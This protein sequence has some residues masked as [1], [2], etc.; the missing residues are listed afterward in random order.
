MSSLYLTYLGHSIEV[1]EG[2]SI[3][4]RALS[5]IL[6]FNEPSVSRQHCRLRVHGG[7]VTIT[8]LGSSNGTFVNGVQISSSTEL[9]TN[10]V[11][12][13]GNRTFTVVVGPP[14]DGA[15]DKTS[16]GV[17]VPPLHDLREASRSCPRCHTRIALSDE[18]CPHCGHVDPLD[19]VHVTT[20]L[21]KVLV[22]SAERRQ[23]ARHRVKLRVIYSSEHQTFETMATS[24]S[25]RGAFVLAD[26]PDRIRTEC[27]LTMLADGVPAITLSAWVVNLITDEAEGP[28]GMG[29]EFIHLRPIEVRWLDDTI[30][31]LGSAD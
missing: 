12:Q 4:G 26:E 18:G 10:D 17:L 9:H 25:R 24:L 14:E 2:D 13:L 15:S 29:I 22:E 6:R 11:I 5:C 19:L 23:H 27:Q 20:E 3:V 1:P 31:R 8:D 28:R 16:P 7:R 30:V 21:P